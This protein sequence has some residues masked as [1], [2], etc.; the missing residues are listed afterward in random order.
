ML[1]SC[2]DDDDKEIICV[3]MA[4]EMLRVVEIT[5]K[6]ISLNIKRAVDSKKK[7]RKSLDA[8]AIKCEKGAEKVLLC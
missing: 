1:N 2:V 5:Q 6:K 4:D 7:D 8:V 3:F